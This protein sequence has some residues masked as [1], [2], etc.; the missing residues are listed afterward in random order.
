MS[1]E[2]RSRL[3]NRLVSAVGAGKRHAIE[4]HIRKETRVI[5]ELGQLEAGDFGKALPG[6]RA[7][8]A[9][10]H[11]LGKLIDVAG[12]EGAE[13]SSAEHGKAEPLRIVVPTAVSCQVPPASFSGIDTQTH[14]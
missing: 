4:I 5:V 9:D 1:A 2:F 7:G 12:K 6:L 11:Q 8:I 14:P 10:G 13:V 3:G